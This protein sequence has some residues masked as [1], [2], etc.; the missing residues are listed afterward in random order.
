MPTYTYLKKSNLRSLNTL[1]PHRHPN[2]HPGCR[3]TYSPMHLPYINHFWKPI[4]CPIQMSSFREHL[5]WG[6]GKYWQTI[7][8]SRQECWTHSL[9]WHP[10]R[11]LQVQPLVSSSYY[12]ILLTCGTHQSF[13]RIA[14][15]LPVYVPKL[16]SNR[17]HRVMDHM[18]GWEPGI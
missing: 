18:V 4:G 10:L 1:A 17:S 9:G 2:R 7:C 5:I 16:F 6:C 12:W 11:L 3:F 8:I 14:I 13:I 15:R